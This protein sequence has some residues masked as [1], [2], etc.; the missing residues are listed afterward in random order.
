MTAKTPYKFNGVIL[1]EETLLKTDQHFAEIDRACIDEVLSGQQ[2]VNNPAEYIALG[3]ESRGKFLSGNARNS[4][5]YLQ[6][7]YWIQTAECIALLS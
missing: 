7:A 3:E 1:T 4:V 6:R 5:T 2:K